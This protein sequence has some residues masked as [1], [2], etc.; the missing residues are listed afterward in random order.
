MNQHCNG[1]ET[2]RERHSNFLN[3][4]IEQDGIYL[5][6]IITATPDLLKSIIEDINDILI[7]SD[8]FV[9]GV[10]TSLY[11]KT[12]NNLFAYSDYRK[13]KGCIEVYEELLGSSVYCFYC[14]SAS[15]DIIS[16]ER[17]NKRN[18]KKALF[19]LD[20]FYLRSKYPYL[21][22]C[23][24]N[25]IPCCHSCN[26]SIRGTLDFD[27]ETHIN[28]YFTSFD[29]H[30]TFSVNEAELA[31]LIMGAESPITEIYVN[32]LETSARNLDRTVEDLLINEKCNLE[33]QKI[34]SLGSSYIRH[35]FRKAAELELFVELV[36]GYRYERIPED[37]KYIHEYQH[38]KLQLDFIE[39]LES[40]P[41]E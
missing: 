5:D 11:K 36:Y 24:Y 32:K 6:S 30:Y 37:K 31:S 38:S 14:N 22:L 8:F 9:D 34:N 1:D 23:F 40:S 18:T 4:F 3:Y 13:T 33:L 16:K 2:V 12:K 26:S 10:Y 25:L 39:Q 15:L 35:K 29:E 28:P 21:S 27:I 17:H 20:H 41:E 19:D 7:E